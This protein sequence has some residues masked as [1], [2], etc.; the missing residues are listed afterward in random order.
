[1][2]H[3]HP[4][5]CIQTIM[6][7]THLIFRFTWDK[8]ESPLDDLKCMVWSPYFFSLVSHMYPNSL[9]S[10]TLT[11]SLQFLEPSSHPPAISDILGYAATSSPD[12]CYFFGQE[13]HLSCTI[14]P[15][16][17]WR[18]I[19]L[20]FLCHLLLKLFPIIFILSCLLSF[21]KSSSLNLQAKVP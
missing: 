10:T 16:R 20:D 11:L 8:N 2:Y 12:T 15:P 21:Y 4:L 7:K 6:F 5:S 19:Y 13:H 17:C 3:N 18:S 14:G 9:P 1:M